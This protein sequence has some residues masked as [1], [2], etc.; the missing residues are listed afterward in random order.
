MI[1]LNEGVP[2]A[3]LQITSDVL[4]S[5]GSKGSLCFADRLENIP[6]GDQEIA[7]R[8]LLYNGWVLEEWNPKPGLARHMGSA[9]LI[10]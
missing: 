8:E 2:R 1:Y 3:L 5:T 6:G 10:K 9:S 4:K 7:K